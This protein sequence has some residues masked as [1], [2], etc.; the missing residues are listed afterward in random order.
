MHNISRGAV[1]KTY[2]FETKWERDAEDTYVYSHMSKYIICDINT[3]KI[4]LKESWK[5]KNSRLL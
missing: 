2:I 4:K 1:L 3:M 5:K